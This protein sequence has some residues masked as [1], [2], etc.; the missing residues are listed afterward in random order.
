[1]PKHGQGETATSMAEWYTRMT[2]DIPNE[3]QTESSWT[4]RVPM[5][6]LLFVCFTAAP[7]RAEDWPQYRGPQRNDVS[8]E[9]GLL[10]KWPAGGPPLLWTYKSAGIGY[11]GVAI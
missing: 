3:N 8:T 4:M 6:A 9:T 10:E 5:L 2:S 11:S 7:L 1:M